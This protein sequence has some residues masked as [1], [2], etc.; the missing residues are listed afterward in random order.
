[1]KY[2]EGD[3]VTVTTDKGKHTGLVMPSKGDLVVKLDSGYN[4]GIKRSKIK[5]IKAVKVRVTPKKKAKVVRSK[6]GLPTIV[7]LSTGGTISS[8]VDYKT[9]AVHAS[10]DASELLESTPELKS[11]ANIVCRPIM[12]KMSE[13]IGPNE[14][15]K[16]ARE[17][18]KELKKKN[19]AGVVITHGTDTMHYTSSALSFMLEDLNKPVVLTGSQRSSDR[20][21]SD[22]RMNLVC[23]VIAATSNVAEVSICMHATT[24]DTYCHL[25]R[26]TKVRKMHTSRRDAFRSLNESPI[27]RVYPSGKVEYTNSYRRR[28]DISPK[29]RAGVEKYVGLVYIYP[30][31]DPDVINWYVKRKYKGLV[32]I[33][34]GLGHVSDK[35]IGS[36]RSAVK[37][38]VKVYMAPQCLSGRL[39]TDVYSNGRKLAK[40]GAVSLEDM[41]P[42]T[43]YVKLVWALGQEKPGLMTENL[44]GEITECSDLKT[45]EES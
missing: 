20:G 19:V 15:A 1:M 23:S 42:E 31:I 40:A 24:E 11:F 17:T 35:I 29:L 27:A 33:A 34:T 26:G 30:G 25:H 2:K 37:K 22:S 13:N 14:W 10:L 28:S 12:N 3:K 16:I 9:G 8:K 39:N 36:V 32:L 4:I 45:F 44:R 7:I 6:S 18:Y 43:A 21:S 38:G 5:Q 41:L